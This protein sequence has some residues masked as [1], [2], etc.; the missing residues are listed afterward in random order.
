MRSCK[1][2]L[3]ATTCSSARCPIERYENQDFRVNRF[4][5][6]ERNKTMAALSQATVIVMVPPRRPQNAG[7][8]LHRI[9]LC[10]AITVLER[11][12]KCEQY[13]RLLGGLLLQNDWGSMSMRLRQH[14]LAKDQAIN[15]GND[16]SIMAKATLTLAEPGRPQAAQWF[17]DQGLK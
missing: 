8:R 13:S 3:H 12:R 16:W 15:P 7:L 14:D 2:V 11:Y 10:N 6:P 4:F 9:C 5:F 17:S 1:S